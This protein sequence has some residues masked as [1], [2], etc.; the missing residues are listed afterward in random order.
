M[1]RGRPSLRAIEEGVGV[2][3]KRGVVIEINPLKKSPFDLYVIRPNDL[4]AVKVKRVRS[5][6]RETKD[7]S[8]MFKDGIAEIRSQQLPSLAQCEFWTLAPWGS[9]QFFLI[10]NDRIIEISQDGIPIQSSEQDPEKPTPPGSPSVFLAETP[11][12]SAPGSGFLCPF[13]AQARG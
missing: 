9:W 10:L 12:V 6:I 11:R 2:A 5:C 3:A 1:T 8:V 7:L 13:Y 4:V